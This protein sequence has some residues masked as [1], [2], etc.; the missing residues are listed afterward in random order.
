MRGEGL[1]YEDLLISQ[2]P[3]DIV[4]ESSAFAVARIQH[5]GLEQ[6]LQ[7]WIE[8]FDFDLSVF[9][10]NILAHS[11]ASNSE[12][13]LYGL[14][15]SMNRYGL[16][17]N[18]DI[19]DTFAVPYPEDGMTWDE[20]YDL[21]R[22][23]TR[24]YEGEEYIGFTA[25]PNNMLLNNQL[26]LGPL[27]LKENKAA[28]NTDQWKLL[29]E[30]LGRFYLLSESGFIPT[31]DAG[32]GR[33]AMVLD[34]VA[35]SGDPDS[36]INWDVASVPML[37]ERPN[38]GLKPASLSSFLS[39]TSQN[40]DA[41]FQVMA[42]LVSEEMQTIMTRQRAQGTPLT[43]TAVKESFGQDLPQWIGKNV[44]ALYHYPD[45][46]PQDPRDPGLEDV[47]VDFAGPMR[48]YV[49]EGKDINTV[50][51]QFEEKINQDIAAKLGES[52]N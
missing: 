34:P 33:L 49:L 32:K 52:V 9:E 35:F 36:A 13:K 48:E 16:H 3:I 39:K 24:T 12:G 28:V 31:G 50:L 11:Y 22:N 51:R 2:T 18:K 41:A 8:K 38:T 42:Y 47:S 6:D 30:S 40:K 29:Y 19:F 44:G 27:D 17:Y 4:Y 20:A 21:A 43:S 25:H 14:P 37:K 5:H 23:L 46:P 15:F 1:Q 45:A 10:P 26:S 7:P